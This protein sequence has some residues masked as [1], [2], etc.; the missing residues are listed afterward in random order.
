[1]IIKGKRD[2][3]NNNR[4]YEKEIPRRLNQKNI[5]CHFGFVRILIEINK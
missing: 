1:M 5:P 2:I 4:K 3:I